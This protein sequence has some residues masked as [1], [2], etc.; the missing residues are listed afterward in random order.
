MRDLVTDPP[1]SA[2]GPGAAPAAPPARPTPRRRRRALRPGRLVLYLAL[3]SYCLT[4]VGAFV[5]TVSISLKSNGEFFSSSPW[6]LPQSPTLD[7]YRDAWTTAHIGQFFLN[8]VLVTAG[9][10]TVSLA[11]S[12]MAAYVLG[13]VEFRGNGAIS[14]VFLSGLM[15]PGFLVIVPLYFLLRDLGLLGSLL[16]LSIVYVA[17][18]IP[19]SVFV[20]TG[21]FR[22]LPQELEEAAYVDGASA[23]MTFARVM[24]PLAGPGLASVALLNA[25]TIWNEFFFALVFL[26]GPEPLDAAARDLPAGD[27]RR[28]QR[29]VDADVRRPGAGDAP[30]A[31]GVRHRPG[32]HHPRPHA[33]GDQGMS[34]PLSVALRVREEVGVARVAELARAGVAFA[35]GELD[36]GCGAARS[37][38]RAAR[39]CRCRRGS[40]SAGATARCAG[41]PWPSWPTFPVRARRPTCWRPAARSPTRRCRWACARRR[42]ASPSTPGAVAFEVRREPFEPLAG[43]PGITGVVLELVDGDGRRAEPRPRRR[44]AGARRARAAGRARGRQRVSCAT[45]TA[46][47]CTTPSWSS[48]PWRG[49]AR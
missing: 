13:R 40:W 33:G 21:F 26:T 49:G 7:N 41:R 34:G 44:R 2:D 29:A 10:V 31:G 30:R 14:M 9:S 45:S 5:W 38:G 28:V 42:R 35:P 11:L 47:A 6:A 8:S 48:R 22:T 23:L 36:D 12:A 16:G 19:F 39:P 37:G 17:T 43:L 24:L 3:V 18:Q 20:L 46:T 32:A 15:I 1:L 4:S 27:Q 25:L